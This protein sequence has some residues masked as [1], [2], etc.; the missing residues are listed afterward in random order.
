MAGLGVVAAGGWPGRRPSLAHP[1]LSL[2]LL[3][4][5]FACGLCLRVE[6]FCQASIESHGAHETP[7]SGGGGGRRGAGGLVEES[8]LGHDSAP[9]AKKKQPLKVEMLFSQSLLMLFLLGS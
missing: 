1:S 8:R 9:K 3:L 7:E 5:L 6:G 2:I 4:S